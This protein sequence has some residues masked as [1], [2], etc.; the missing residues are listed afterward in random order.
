MKITYVGEQSEDEER[1]S[2][3]AEVPSVAGESDHGADL[4]LD[5]GRDGHGAFNDDTSIK[6]LDELE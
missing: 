1:V 3:V 6:F 5:C 4:D 2:K